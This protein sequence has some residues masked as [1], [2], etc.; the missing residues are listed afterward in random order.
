MA[1]GLS[2]ERTK[3]EKIN[4]NHIYSITLLLHYYGSNYSKNNDRKSF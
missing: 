4:K 3:N 2:M 1:L